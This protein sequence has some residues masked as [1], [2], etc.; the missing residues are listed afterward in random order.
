MS[1]ILTLFNFFA[2]WF[3]ISASWVLN[4]LGFEVPNVKKILWGPLALVTTEKII[5]DISFFYFFVSMK[6]NNKHEWEK[7]RVRA[8]FLLFVL[9]FDHSS[10][11]F[12]VERRSKFQVN[13]MYYLLFFA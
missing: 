9:V 2:G 8:L 11:F 1:S 13:F 6:I 3:A 5:N 7:V 12:F 4:Q 10:V